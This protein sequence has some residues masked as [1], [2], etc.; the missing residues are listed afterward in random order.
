M[1]LQQDFFE[2]I[3]RSSSK[4]RC[5]LFFDPEYS[6]VY[7]YE[8]DHLGNFTKTYQELFKT[9]D[10]NFNYTL[11][12]INLD[13]QQDRLIKIKIVDRADEN[14]SI[15]AATISKSNLSFEFGV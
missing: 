10:V 11:Q 5:T 6:D 13:M 1:N 15:P 12:L 4:L 9:S 2:D 7:K 8:V 3:I 14:I